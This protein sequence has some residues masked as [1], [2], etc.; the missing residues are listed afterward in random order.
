MHAS[1]GLVSVEKEVT[2]T[3]LHTEDPPYF[4]PSR[5]APTVGFVGIEYSY[6]ARALSANE[7]DAVQI[8]YQQG[9]TG[10]DDESVAGGGGSGELVLTWEPQTEHAGGRH[11]VRLVAKDAADR[12]AIQEWE[13]VVDNSPPMNVVVPEGKF[14]AGNQGL[15]HCTAED[16][17]GHELH[18]ELVDGPDGMTIDEATGVV[19]WTPGAGHE[20]GPHAFRVRALDELDAATEAGSNA[21]V[22]K[23][24]DG[25]NW[26]TS[27]IPGEDPPA[28]W[29][30]NGFS[31]CDDDDRDVHE[32]C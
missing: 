11:P 5:E 28:E 25:D 14:K 29:C 1:D 30:T 16:R 27:A 4:D 17:D 2:V 8:L 22:W 15:V 32:G 3:V 23:D 10:M 26:C 19:S 21:Y 24:L 31:D 13:I 6:R 20:G 7:C 12:T 18:W 9:P